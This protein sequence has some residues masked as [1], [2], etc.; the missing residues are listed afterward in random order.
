MVVA[1]IA[2]SSVWVITYIPSF[3]RLKVYIPGAVVDVIRVV[4]QTK[5]LCVLKSSAI[6]LEIVDNTQSDTLF[7]FWEEGHLVA[8]I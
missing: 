6:I 1:S 4:H 3:L 5:V 8:N 7:L 2:K